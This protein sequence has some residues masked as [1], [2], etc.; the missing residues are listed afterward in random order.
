MDG[1]VAHA[2]SSLGLLLPVYVE[3]SLRGMLRRESGE[4]AAIAALQAV[5][6]LRWVVSEEGGGREPRVGF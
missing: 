3:E 5:W 2:L 4:M 1:A 6:K